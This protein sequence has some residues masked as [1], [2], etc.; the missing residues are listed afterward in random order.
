MG[1]YADAQI[2]LVEDVKHIKEYYYQIV[3]DRRNI[4]KKNERCAKINAGVNYC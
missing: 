3:A 2:K 4:G 1:I